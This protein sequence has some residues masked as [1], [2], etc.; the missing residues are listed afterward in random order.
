M[1]QPGISRDARQSDIS[2]TV[3]VAS[4]N[5]VKLEA[6][7]LAFGRMFTDRAFEFATVSVPSGVSDQPASSTETREGACRRA[8]AA[9]IAAPNASYWVGIEGGI[10]D[11]TDGMAAFAWVVIESEQRRGQGRTATFFLPQRVAELV[12]GGMELGHADDLVFGRV[13]SKQQDGAIGLL[14][15]GVINRTTLYE[16]G[17]VMALVPFKSESLYEIA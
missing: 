7:R 13:N 15:G 3:V 14:T 6:V 2:S 10:E 11:T 1:A 16:P 4:T 9:R 17:V 8:E 12:R 5:P